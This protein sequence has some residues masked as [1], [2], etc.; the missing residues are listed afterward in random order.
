M[1][2]VISPVFA[3]ENASSRGLFFRCGETRGRPGAVT[4]SASPRA[5][6]PNEHSK[7][8]ARLTPSQRATGRA[9]VS[10]AVSIS[11]RV[12]MLVR[13]SSMHSSPSPKTPDMATQI[14]VFVVN[15]A[16]AVIVSLSQDAL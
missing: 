11:R 14:V 2:P 5:E 1:S 7:E 15:L 12:P 16:D 3:P 4:R 6:I 13:A 9:I 10:H 8:R